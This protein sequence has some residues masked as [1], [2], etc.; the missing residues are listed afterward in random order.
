MFT[1]FKTSI[2]YKK[3]ATS[4][5]ATW[6]IRSELLRVLVLALVLW[7]FL[8]VSSPFEGAATKELII[9]TLEWLHGG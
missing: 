8:F 4:A 9:C 1:I 3:T 2:L 7:F 5:V 6:I